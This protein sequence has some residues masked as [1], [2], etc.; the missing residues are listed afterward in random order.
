MRRVRYYEY[1]GPEV[2][3]VEE[4]DPPQ[5]GPGE[6]LIRTEGVGANFVDTKIRRGPA[7]GSIFHRPLLFLVARSSPEAS[8]FMM[9]LRAH[10]A[11]STGRYPIHRPSRICA[12]T[13]QL[14]ARRKI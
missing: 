12:L 7:P 2:L 5:P 11:L 8:T 1:G 14:V 3:Q 9:V 6:V 10:L 4:A 13:T